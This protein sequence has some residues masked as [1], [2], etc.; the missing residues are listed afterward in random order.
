MPTELLNRRS[1]RYE[2]G[3]AI[4]IGLIPFFPTLLFKAVLLRLYQA[5]PRCG[6]RVRNDR[7]WLVQGASP[8]RRSE[9]GATWVSRF[10]DRPRPC[11]G[12]GSARLRRAAAFVTFARGNLGCLLLA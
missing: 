8:N 10:R 1:E 4:G 2:K 3:R 7:F 11:I 9:T 5:A 6:I 12:C